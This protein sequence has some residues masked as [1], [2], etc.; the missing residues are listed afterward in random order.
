MEEKEEEE[1][2]ASKFHTLSGEKRLRGF[3]GAGAAAKFEWL[4]SRRDPH[5]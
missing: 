5:P 4:V 2:V 1:K 3:P